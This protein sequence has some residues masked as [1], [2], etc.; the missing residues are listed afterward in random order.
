MAAAA[1]T[2]SGRR[3]VS[4]AVLAAFL[5]GALW[6]ASALHVS[7]SLER[8]LAV[9]C[10]VWGHEESCFVAIRWAGTA[11]FVALA[12]AVALS[13][14]E[15]ARRREQAG[16]AKG[17]D[18]GPPG[19]EPERDRASA[20][21]IHAI[22][23]YQIYLMPAVL[24]IVGK[25]LSYAGARRLVKDPADQEAAHLFHTG[26]NIHNAAYPALSVVHCCSVI[27]YMLLRLVWFVRDNCVGSSLVA[28]DAQM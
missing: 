5:L 24:F 21:T 9:E 26:S 12:S 28:C 16:G 22:A 27:P 20:V 25:A 19:R 13:Y 3:L 11:G 6:L 8:F 23:L 1:R 2:P 18:E 4:L 17:E 14:G 15:A 7:R 10:S